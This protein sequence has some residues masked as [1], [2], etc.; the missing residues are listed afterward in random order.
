MSGE[1][2]GKFGRVP[3]ILRILSKD[4]YSEYELNNNEYNTP[5]NVASQTNAGQS[6]QPNC[7]GQGTTLPN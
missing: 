1:I 4:S 2:F 5:E 3:T 7:G 6:A